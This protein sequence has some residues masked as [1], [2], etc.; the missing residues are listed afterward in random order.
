MSKMISVTTGFQYSVNINY[1]INNEDKIKNFIPTNSALKFIE[2]ILLSTDDKSTERARVLVGPYGKGKSHM[3]LTTMALLMKRDCSLFAHINDKLNENKRFKNILD[4]YYAQDSKILPVI[5][6]G[7]NSSIPQAFL[8]ALESTLRANGLMN[9]MPDTNYKAAVKCIHKWEQDFPDV[10]KRFQNL[11]QDDTNR[12][13]N[14]LLSYDVSAYQKFEKI[15][16]ELSAGAVFNPFLGFDIVELYES[17]L[18]GLKGKGYSGIYVIYDEFSKY[19][20][21]NI[22]TAS[23]SDM[24][25]L[26]DFAEKC[27]RSGN[28]QLHL[29]LICHKEISNYID[30]LP[31]DKTDGWRGVSERFKHIHLSDNFSQ[32]Y[33]IMETVINHDNELWTQFTTKYTEVFSNL[34]AQYIKHPMFSTLQKVGIAKLIYECYPLHPTTSFILPRLS[35]RIAQNERTLFTF[36]SADSNYTLPYYLR[37]MDETSFKLLTPDYVYDYFEPLMEKEIYTGEIHKNYVMTRNI[38]DKIKGKTLQMSIVKVLSLMYMIEQFDSLHPDKEEIINVFSLQ[39]P[40]EEIE[41]ALDELIQKEYVIYL[42]RSNGYLRLKQ[43]SG[44]DLN[45]VINDRI[46]SNTN[47]ETKNILN[48]FNFYKFMYPSKYNDDREMIRY[49]DFIFIDSKEVGED[50]KWNIKRENNNSD[51]TIYAILPHD[52]SE[53]LRVE[54]VLY[55]T[56][57]TTKNVICILPKEYRNMSTVAK[58]LYAVYELRE[59]AIGDN[60]LYNEYDVIYDDLYDVVHRYIQSFTKPEINESSYYHLGSNVVI[61]RKSEL[62]ALLSDICDKV[63]DKTPI[64]NNEVINKDEIT[65]VAVNSRSKVLN[66]LLR[67]EVEENLGLVG[68]GQDVSIMRSVLLRTGILKNAGGAWEITTSN[69][70]PNIS[71]VLSTI[72]QF[73]L[74]SNKNESQSF[75]ILYQKLIS[76]EYG[77]GLRKGVIP[78][79]IAVLLH[80]YKN[81]VQ[82]YDRNTQVQLNADT[83]QQINAQPGLFYLERINWTNEKAQYVNAL[84]D[85]FSEYTNDA[86]KN[87]DSYDHVAIAIKR[88]Y[89]SLPK[90]SKDLKVKNFNLEREDIRFLRT[91][92]NFRNNTELLFKS[93][94]EIYECDFSSDEILT[95]VKASKRKYDKAIY[96]LKTQIEEF[97]YKTF[98]RNQDKRASLQSIILDWCD[99]L[100]ADTFSQVFSNETAK[101]LTLCQK[102]SGN[103]NEFIDHVAQLST[104][105]RVIDWEDST[106]SKCTERILLYKVTAESFKGTISNNSVASISSSYSLSFIDKEGNLLTKRFSKVSCSPRAKLLMNSLSADLDAM[107]QSISDEE[108]RQVLIDLLKNLY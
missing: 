1:D 87:N 58:E 64:I 97:I 6:S 106:I 28:D 85:I 47:I 105:L 86:E 10:F 30:I 32:T 66:A 22:K 49:F 18:K 33:E 73:I 100:H 104:G 59:N 76:P 48:E 60:V 96:L 23:V 26:Q 84:D 107:G 53:I 21:A 50:T 72:E 5:V 3:V 31:K 46:H 91:I 82:I 68:S 24:K 54:S 15:Y 62:S 93:L 63:Y 12:F 37:N 70:D 55:K 108:K 65:T 61:H 77:I 78:I 89:L 36:L 8:I 13:T 29:I 4:K 11:I 40:I 43:S 20:E 34:I 79:F 7:S 101:F 2:E 45:K 57:N 69:D 94:P 98:Y 92:R 51:G 71:F 67:S 80:Q 90:F 103:S 99:H 14:K 39:Y 88:W 56:T 17:V 27:N 74:N 75:E 95:K 83:L 44:V 25:M 38:L 19:L 16:P 35:E 81:S 9:I 41:N 102:I 42:K 52:E